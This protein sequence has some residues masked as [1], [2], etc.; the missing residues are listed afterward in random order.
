MSLSGD[1][2]YKFGPSYLK[3][4]PKQPDGSIALP[5]TG[6]TE[7][8]AFGG[9]GPFD[10]SGADVTIGAVPMVIKIN[11][12]EESKDLDLSTAAVPSAVTATELIAAIT[13]AAY[14]GVTSSVDSRGYPKI[15]ITAGDPEVDYIQVYGQAAKLSMFG[16]GYGL[17]FIHVDTMT[18]FAFTP[19]N[20][21][22]EKIEIV[23]NNNQKT[24][25]I[26]PG[27]RDGV[28]ATLTDAATDDEL[29]ALLTG[30]SYE[31][32]SGYNEFV[33]PLP[34]AVKTNMSVEVVNRLYL[35]N[36]NQLDDWVGAKITRALNLTAKEDSEGDGAKTWQTPGYSLS[37]TPYTEPETKTKIS[38]SYTRTYSRADFNALN[39]Y[40]V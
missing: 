2:D 30:G 26:F 18:T 34:D 32:L 33:P 10:F 19:T 27:Y 31:N 35:K 6:K 39:Y 16:N 40:S 11:D 22:D 7:S 3:F 14:T 23:D 17:K 36:T 5:Y 4:L 15:V 13:T 24:A 20:V 12:S 1:A 37:G 21:D 28:T 29:R 38:D 8:A 9:L 25:V